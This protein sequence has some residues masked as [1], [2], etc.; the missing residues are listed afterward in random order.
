MTFNNTIYGELLTAVLPRRIE[1]EAENERVLK[2]IEGLMA[3]DENSLSPEQETL[4]VL[5]AGLVEEFEE[6]TY[7]MSENTP[8]V[9]TN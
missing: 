4:L 1:T 3:K 6:Q 8:L 5:L 9:L 7:P 2:I